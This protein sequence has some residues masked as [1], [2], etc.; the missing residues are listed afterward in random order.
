V[1]VD[2]FYSHTFTNPGHIG[3]NLQIL[4]LKFLN[5]GGGLDLIYQNDSQD[6]MLIIHN[7]L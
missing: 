7:R 4:K 2:S 5:Y 1:Q 3:L 6:G